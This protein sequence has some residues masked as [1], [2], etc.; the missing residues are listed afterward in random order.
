MNLSATLYTLAAIG[1]FALMVN[2]P[3]IETSSHKPTNP[4]ISTNEAAS[5]TRTEP[6]TLDQLS[7]ETI[8]PNEPP[9]DSS[10]PSTT[11]PTSTLQSTN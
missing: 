2:R 7:A 6:A 9:K 4:P 10:T 11:Q 1:F 3:V 8:S 5:P